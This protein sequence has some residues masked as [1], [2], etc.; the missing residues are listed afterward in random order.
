MIALIGTHEVSREQARECGLLFGSLVGKR[1]HVIDVASGGR[2]RF[3]AGA[4]ADGL[5]GLSFYAIGIG[6]NEVA[7]VVD[8]GI[9]IENAAG[10]HVRCDKAIEVLSAIPRR[11]AEHLLVIQAE[12]RKSF[13]P[14]LLAFLAIGDVDPGVAIIVACDVRREAERDQSGRIDDKLA[15]GHVGLRKT[16][17]RKEQEWEQA[18]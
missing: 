2:L 16:E 14:L 9:Q 5:F 12:H 15:W 8:A 1:V 10:K 11:A 6:Q 3:G 7:F 4:N 17:K 13:A 18:R